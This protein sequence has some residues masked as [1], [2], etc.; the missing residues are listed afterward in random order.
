MSEGDAIL[1]DIIANPADDGLRL[2]YADWCEDNGQAERAEFIRVQIELHRGYRVDPTTREY[3]ESG[4]YDNAMI[5]YRVHEATW[6]ANLDKRQC[7]LFRDSGPKWWN[8]LPGSYRATVE[9]DISIQTAEG[10][11]YLVRRGFVSEVKCHMSLWL[12]HGK[13]ICAMHPVERVVITDR[14]PLTMRF[15]KGWWCHLP[16]YPEQDEHDIPLN[17]W[18]RLVGHIKGEP[19]GSLYWKIYRS[20]DDAHAALSSA[21]LAHAKQLTQSPTAKV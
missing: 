2:I 11:N 8:G 15:G 20:D 21:C 9:A 1:Q 12:D 6:K 5:L 4:E 17:L 7:A 14:E 10:W 16:E 18:D 3:M 19:P 13:D